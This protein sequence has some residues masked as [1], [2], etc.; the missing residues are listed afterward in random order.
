MN[1]CAP[2]KITDEEFQQL[3]DEFASPM[4]P[5]PT[6]SQASIAAGSHVASLAPADTGKE[7]QVALPTKAVHSPHTT[8]ELKAG[9][10]VRQ[11][12]SVRFDAGKRS[13]RALF[14]HGTP[15]VSQAS[16]AAGSH[17]ASL[18]PAGTVKELQVAL[19]TKAVH[20]PH[21]TTE[22]KAGASVRQVDSVRF[23]SG[24]RSQRGLFHHWTPTPT[25][26]Q[27]SIAAGS[28]V[29]SLAPAG[30]V[31]ESQVAEAT[32]AVHSP[33]TTTELK[34]GASVRHADSVRFNSGKRSQRAL[35]HHWADS[36]RFDSTKRSQRGLFHQFP[37]PTIV[38]L[39]KFVLPLL[40][41]I[42]PTV[43]CA[44]AKNNCDYPTLED[45]F[46]NDHA[47]YNVSG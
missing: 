27:A 24:K 35:F 29:A 2:K 16:I 31:T 10:S 6:V 43:H 17:V 5:T 34:A 46:G 11:A 18:A 9:A 42:S 36:V 45:V 1:V 12:D 4:T 37:L 23:D 19:P 7:L 13:Q 15:T 8:T 39:L 32:K 3:L 40:M 14:H 21:T 47:N 33:H 44:D 22:L 41:L 25:V 28:H 20:S 26:S 30:T 38:F